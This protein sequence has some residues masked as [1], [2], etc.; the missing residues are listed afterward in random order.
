MTAKELRSIV[1]SNPKP[2]SWREGQ[3]VFNVVDSLYGVAR[4]AQF[5]YGVDCFY[6]D[7]KIDEFLEVCA[8]ILTESQEIS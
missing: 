3:F 6:N 5:E 8:K 7:D 2:K 1:Y 4:I